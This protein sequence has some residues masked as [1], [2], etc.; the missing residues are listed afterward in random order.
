MPRL[1][2]LLSF[3]FLWL[4]SASA[5]ASNDFQVQIGDDQTISFT[6][7]ASTKQAAPKPVKPGLFDLTYIG[8]LSPSV[9]S[10][11]YFLFGGNPCK[12][13]SA[14]RALYLIR[15]SASSSTPKITSFVQPG[16]IFDP[17]S[18]ALVMESR[19][20]YG[21]CLTSH[22]DDADDVYVVFQKERID[23]RHSLQLSVFVADA[24]GDFLR[25]RLIERGMP[26]INRTLSLVRSK[27]CHEIEGR[28][29]VMVLKPHGLNWRNLQPSDEDDEDKDADSDDSAPGAED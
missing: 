28:N 5:Y 21:H 18:R 23:R 22:G 13:C 26:S 2:S 6:A 12:T 15:P 27:K 29:R 11:P 8:A 10:M 3:C 17:K 9:E 25:E 16:K 7:A 20:F 19:A 24:S 4:V 14:E 1:L